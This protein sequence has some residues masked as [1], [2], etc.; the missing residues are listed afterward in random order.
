MGTIP[1]QPPKGLFLALF[2]LPIVPVITPA[3]DYIMR[4]RARS[5]KRASGAGHFPAVPAPVPALSPAHAPGRMP[6]MK[7]RG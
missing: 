2:P 7:P 4:L 3:G 1:D 6:R 5:V